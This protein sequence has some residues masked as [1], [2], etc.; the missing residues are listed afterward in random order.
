MSLLIG[1]VHPVLVSHSLELR[2]AGH[3][4]KAKRVDLNRQGTSSRLNVPDV[5]YETE[6]GVL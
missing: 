1:V 6:G 2:S 3:H 4:F 5:K